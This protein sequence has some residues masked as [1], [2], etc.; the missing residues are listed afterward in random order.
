MLS[1]FLFLVVFFKKPSKFNLIEVLLPRD[2]SEPDAH[3]GAKS[4]D[5]IFLGY[6]VHLIID[7]KSQLP[8]DVNVAHLMKP[9]HLRLNLCSVKLQKDILK[10]RWIHPLWTPPMI[11]IRTIATLSRI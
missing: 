7:A 11:A 2:Y 8:L 5:Y 4:E 3:W 9:I 10:S 6:K 1:P